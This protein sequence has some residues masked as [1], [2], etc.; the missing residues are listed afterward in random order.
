MAVE[1]GRLPPEIT[2]F[3]GRQVEIADVSGLVR[4]HRLVTL[5]GPGGVGKTRLSAQ[6]GN[7]VSADFLDGVWFI[8]LSQTRDPDVVPAIV[9]EPFDVGD[10]STAD[11]NVLLDVLTEYLASRRILLILDNCE[12]VPEAATQVAGRILEACPDVTV[13]ATTRRTLGLPGEIVYRVA[14]LGIEGGRSDAVRLFLDRL[15]LVDA[16]RRPDGEELET[17]SAI[18]TRV[19]GLPLAIELSASRTKLLSTT[20]I[21]ERLTDRFELLTG[22]RD[23]PER[24]ETLRA[25]MAWSYELLEPAEQDALDRLAIFNGWT[26]EAAEAVLG[27]RASDLLERLLDSSLVDVEDAGSVRRYRML[28]TVRQYGQDRLAE[29]GRTESARADHA[30]HFLDFA[31]R[32]DE[33]LRSAEQA[34]WIGRVRREHDNIRAALGWAFDSADAELALRLVAATGR[35]W[36]MQTHW[37][38][39]LAWFERATEL[40]GGEHELDWARAYLKTGVIETITQG[41][42]PTDKANRAHRIMSEQGTPTEIGLATYALA[43]SL[44]DTTEL[45]PLMEESLRLLV[46]TGDEWAIAYAKR[47]QGSRVELVGD[48][49]ANVAHQREAVATLTRLGDHWTAAWI[50]FDLGFSLVAVGRYEE[51]RDAFDEALE[52]VDSLDERLV[53]AHAHRGLGA[54]HAGLGDD[55]EARR[56]YRASVPM[57]ERIGDIKCL[58]FARMFLAEV[59]MRISPTTDVRPLLIAAV[60]GFEDKVHEPGVAA[61]YRRLARW[62]LGSDDAAAAA[63]LLGAA[64]ALRGG[65]RDSISPTEVALLDAL[66]SDVR[67]ALAADEAERLSTEGAG[68]DAE[69]RSA[70][71]A[72]LAA[73]SV[74]AAAPA[75]ASADDAT[76]SALTTWPPAYVGLRHQLASAWGLDGDIHIYRTLSGRSGATVLAVDLTTA[77]FSGQAILKLEHTDATNAPSEAERHEQAWADAP[78]FAAAHMPRLVRYDGWGDQAALLATI[79]SGGLEYTVPFA[80]APFPVQLEVSREV[81]TALLGEW[82]ADYRL[83]DA[84]RTPSELLSRWLGYR[85]DPG[86]GRV[87]GLLADAGVDPDAASFILDGTWYPNPLAFA[88]TATDERSGMRPVIGRIHGDLQG[89]NVLVR[90][91]DTDRAW[92]L[93]DHAFYDD[94]APL[95]IDHAYFE[96]ATLLA[97]REGASPDEWLALSDG[98][99]SG[100]GGSADDLGLIELARSIRT[101]AWAWAETAEADRRSSMDAQVRLARVAVGLNFA[102]K[103]IDP[104]QRR[105]GLLYAAVELKRYVA[106]AGTDWP[107]DGPTLTLATR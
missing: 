44:T 57:L 93:I 92:F 55:I 45:V 100:R 1:R 67:S 71:V 20:E 91:T 31:Q 47:W 36:F 42:A 68:L 18:V 82:N 7:A 27:K 95:F 61:V 104:A 12:H 98:I 29:T 103:D 32:S 30:A 74:P 65:D 69:A 84:I 46:A 53:E 2:T 76:P 37:S 48:A 70:L 33:A 51:S 35:F 39:A 58:A 62:A 22:G 89:Y 88:R 10:I 83:D 21:L 97:A 85:L 56:Y 106:F 24:H 9:A 73:G 63:R 23:R 66:E 16:S 17:I 79:A 5:L 107:H 8:D 41:V 102:H 13:L 11:P 3:V 105:L 96:I 15:S 75:A 80:E 101:A 34:G 49:Q 38:E 6:V 72:S 14:P 77:S 43:E 25:T 19:D 90:D 60:G 87:F 52:L 78:S 26:L 4:A 81:A 59:E 28:E 64:S 50:A 94:A 40:A 54:V 86:R 99:A